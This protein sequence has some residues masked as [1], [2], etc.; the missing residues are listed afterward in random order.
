MFASDYDKKGLSGSLIFT[1]ILHVA[2]LL[3]FFNYQHKK[4]LEDYK[5]TEITMLEEVPDEKKPPEI[6]KPKKMFDILKQLIPIKQK[7]DLAMDKPKALDLKKP[8]MNLNKPQ[9]LALDKNKL[10]N[11]KPAMKTLD[12]DNE[13]G[14]KKITPQMVEQQKLAVAQQ[15]QLANAPQKLNISASAARNSFLPSERPAIS[16][17][18]MARAGAGLKGVAV[19]V[20]PT[21]V[22]KKAEPEEK[23]N[24]APQR[25]TQ[26][27]ITGQLSGRAITRKTSPQYPRWAEE[28]GIQAEVA[29]DFT[30][31]ADGSVKDNLMV[32]RTSGY[33]ELDDLAKDALLQFM[34][35]PLSS[36]DDQTGTAVFVYKLSR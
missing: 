23:I 28:Q 31:K 8:E 3:L 36:S 21:P 7:M 14:K 33:P 2:I 22:P 11:L 6:E 26:L 19:K 25:G 17:D 20:E 24:I 5:L 18:A 15:R 4:Q 16:V 12:L 27:L 30:V 35:A 32:S 10:D 1:F 13:I 34:F 9:A 29:I